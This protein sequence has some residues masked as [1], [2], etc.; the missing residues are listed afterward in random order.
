MK[1]HLL[2]TLCMVYLYICIDIVVFMCGFLLSLLNKSNLAP[3]IID[4]V[5]LTA[6]AKLN[7]G[8]M[9]HV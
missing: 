9:K 2:P 5:I 6:R 7:Q 8:L 1:F 3:E 4:M